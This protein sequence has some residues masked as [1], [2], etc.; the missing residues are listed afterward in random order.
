MPNPAATTIGNRIAPLRFILFVALLLAAGGVGAAWLGWRHGVMVGFD[1][2]ALGFLLSCLP[3]LSGTDAAAIRDHAVKNDAN[4][5]LLLVVTGIVMLVV[6][7]TVWVELTNATAARPASPAFII[8][9]L[10]LAWL[11]SNSVYALHYAHLH[12]AQH[13]GRDRGGV[14]FPGRDAPDYWDFVYFAF[15]LGMTFQTSDVAITDRSVRRVV[16]AHCLAAFIFNLGVLAFTINIL[17]H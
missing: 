6:L 16:T 17:G 8:A 12:Y 10:M 4:R 15:T 2:A 1:I 5:L 14:D 11:F 3:L 13:E 7:V 9:T